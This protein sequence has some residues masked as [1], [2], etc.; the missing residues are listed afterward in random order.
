MR[1]SLPEGARR[2]VAGPLSAR[3]PSR[4]T[5]DEL[6]QRYE[7]SR[8]PGLASWCCR[9]APALLH[10]YTGDDDPMLAQAGVLPVDQVAEAPSVPLRLHD[11]QD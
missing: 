10:K 3:P 1:G 11:A 2:T 4:S 6:S 9:P 8:A 5:P 7:A